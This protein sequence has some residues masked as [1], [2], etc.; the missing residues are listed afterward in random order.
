MIEKLNVYCA[1]GWF[2]PNQ[3]ESLTAVE[4]LLIEFTRLKPYLPRHDGVKL[5]PGELHDSSLRKKVFEDNV[6]HI[7]K[8]DFLVAVL[9]GRDGFY[10]TGT[11]WECGYAMSKGKPII[12]YDPGSAV[13]KELRGICNGFEE[14]DSDIDSLE[15]TLHEYIIKEHQPPRIIPS[16]VLFIGP[17]TTQDQR[18]NNRDIVASVIMECHGS[19]FRWVDNLSSESLYN[20]I[21]EVFAGVDYMISVIDDRHP[22]VSWMMGQ[23]YNRKIPVV[24]YTNFDYG[25]NIML[26]CSLLYHCKGK[27]ELN[28]IMQKMKR[29]GVFSLPEFDDSSLRAL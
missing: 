15:I 23:A 18:D 10:D 1:G 19:N 16:K 29:D 6:A 4:S 26:L 14:I 21:D 27:E 17:D 3:N 25:V 2:G 12:V 28:S 22:V 11:L 20:S 7:D 9:D 13:E 8:S 5:T 24:T